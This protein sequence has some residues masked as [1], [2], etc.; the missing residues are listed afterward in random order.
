MVNEA[1]ARLRINALLQQSGWCLSEL[2]GGKVN[3][4]VEDHIVIGEEAD[5]NFGND[6]EK[7][8]GRI[9]YLLLDTND[10]P[11]CVLEAKSSKIHPLSA[12]EQAREYAQTVGVHYVILSNGAE[13]YFWDLR[14]GNPQVIRFFPSPQSI[15]E[16]VG[17]SH[18]I[19]KLIGF[20]VSQSILVET[21]YP[22]Y[23]LDPLWSGDP[24]TSKELI[25]KHELCF[26]RPYQV[27]AI[28]SVQEAVQQGKTRF[29]FEM[30]TGT[31]KTSTA[32]AVIKLFFASGNARRVLFLVDRLELESQ[33][34][35]A[36]KSML[37]PDIT[38]VVYKEH[39]ESWQRADIVVTT[40]QSIL[41]SY[42]T[43]FSP[44][45]FDLIISDEAHR[46]ISGEGANRTVFDYFVGYKLGLTATPKDYLKN[47]TS[48]DIASKDPRE[49]E[50]RAQ[51][52]TYHTFGCDSA[53]PTFSYT[54]SDG[55]KEGFL[56]NPVL[57]DCRTDVT[58]QLLSNKGFAAEVVI[59]ENGTVDEG[60]FTYRDYEKNFYS[61]ATNRVC[62]Q[63]FLKEA[64][65]DPVTSE[66]GK[67]LIF[68]VS[69]NHAAKLTQILNEEADKIWPDRYQSDFALQVTSQVK[70]AQQ[71]TI[72]FANNNLGGNPIWLPGYKTSK[73]RI[74]VT[75]GMMTTGYDCQDIL[76]V[77]LMRPIFSPYE[78]IQIKGRGTRIYTFTY[79]HRQDG[80]T[81]EKSER[82][83]KYKLID[84]FANCEYFQEKY[85]YTA[86][87]KVPS[88][89]GVGETTGRGTGGIIITDPPLNYGKYMG[90][91]I[92]TLIRESYL[93]P[94]GM[95]VDE[96]LFKEAK[97]RAKVVEEEQQKAMQFYEEYVANQTSGNCNPD[98]LQGFFMV[99]WFNPQFL[100]DM[101]RNAII[102]YA[103]R[104]DLYGVLYRIPPEER[105]RI[106]SFVA[107][108][109]G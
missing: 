23:A 44:T 40:I 92:T 57:V 93:P 80:V 71:K 99:C 69:Q 75:V 12:K 97:H 9:D 83:I 105:V 74:C 94:E 86:V 29:L 36:F 61:E 20:P 64:E 91:D 22:E 53:K 89:K 82:K 72:S 10:K 26:L 52:S 45:D 18:D 2:D 66:I 67:T 41:N 106:A 27:Q 32:A 70:D 42:D 37:R 19:E 16:D 6:F 73:T 62:I 38:T 11:L 25:S 100:S 35:K 30:A 63:T 49:I 107:A 108:R 88:P 58:T 96:E 68:A 15:S 39:K 95:K 98:D 102:Q 77:V 34:E 55:V 104:P 14:Q 33:A 28:K 51:Y 43:D 31:G 13:H 59:D 4:K 56:V 50:R 87:L 46:L 109:K 5:T 47:L 79:A 81:A 101:A 8:D 54:L 21:Q 78:F 48:G 76:N 17:V 90:E 85:E 1:Q 103:D 3:V 65:K 60:Q 7:H 24:A 84:F